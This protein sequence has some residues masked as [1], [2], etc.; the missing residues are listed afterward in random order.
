MIGKPLK[1]NLSKLRV[2]K[3][4][5]G[6]STYRPNNVPGHNIVTGWYRNMT[7]DAIDWF[8]HSGT[9]VFACH[10]GTVEVRDN[11]GCVIITNEKYKTVYAHLHIKEGLPKTVKQGDKIGWVGKV[12][13]DPHLHF[14][15]WI[16]GQ[17]V[18]SS[19]PKGL[20]EKLAGLLS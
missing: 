19:T 6:R 10:D 11:I 8:C 15:L 13:K 5:H 4:L 18:T 17:G 3:T 16:D 14:E 2:N 1:L 12:L 9:S 20:S 7:K